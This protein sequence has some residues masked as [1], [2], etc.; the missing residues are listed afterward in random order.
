MKDTTIYPE[1]GETTDAEIVYQVTFGGKFVIKTNLNIKGRGIKK[2][3]TNQ[4]LVTENA[5]IKLKKQYNACSIA[6][7]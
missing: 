5:L 7:L 6:L 2:E 1:M 3:H 4:Y